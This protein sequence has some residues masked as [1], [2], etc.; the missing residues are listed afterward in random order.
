MLVVRYQNRRMQV[1]NKAYTNHKLL[2]DFVVV[3]GLKWW[4]RSFMCLV[5]FSCVAKERTARFGSSLKS[6]RVHSKLYTEI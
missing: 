2:V 5:I 3:V 6:Y 1:I 4:Q